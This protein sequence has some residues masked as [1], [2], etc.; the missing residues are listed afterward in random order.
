MPTITT[1]NLQ[2][3]RQNSELELDLFLEAVY[4][5]YGYDFRSYSRASLRRRVQNQI[6]KLKV[7]NMC[8]LIHLVLNDE[9]IFVNIFDHMTVNVTEM[10][11]DPLFYTSFRDNIIPQLK[12]YPSFKIWHAG[13]ST[14]QEVYSMC[15]L[16][17]EAGLY[18]K[19]QIY[20]T[21]IDHNVLEKA[22]K[23][24]YPIE[25][26]SLYSQNYQD[27]GCLN[28]L[29]DYYTSRYDSIIMD[30]SLKKNIIFADHDLVTD[31]V[32]SEMQIIICR[33]V[34]IYFNQSL[35]DRVFRLFSNSLD[36]G[37]Y[38]CL[39]SKESMRFSNCYKIYDT[40][41]NKYKM[42]KKTRQHEPFSLKIS[43]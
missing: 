39:G 41:D 25:T 34:L 16:L 13:C 27:S 12:S 11:R 28:S 18:D 32:F 19:A 7:N 17:Q 21:D 40:V 26:A 15:I 36:Y 10:F 20:A 38:L 9:K 35:Q 4:R 3:L 6:E 2:S 42:Y 37:G 33:N 22:K 1:P 30:S 8:E 29:S 24:I 23:G 43:D 31:Q 5:K 14:G